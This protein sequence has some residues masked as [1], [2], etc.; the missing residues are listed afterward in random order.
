MTELDYHYFATLNEV[1]DSDNEN[2][3]VL[4]LQKE[5]RSEAV[6]L[7]MKDLSTAYSLAKEIQFKSGQTSE[8]RTI[9]KKSWGQDTC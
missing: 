5:T 1:T 4:M 7:L 8:P 3:Q 2:Q 9:F 6:Y